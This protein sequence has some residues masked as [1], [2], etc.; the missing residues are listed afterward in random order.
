MRPE[1]RQLLHPPVLQHLS[2]LINPT[3]DLQSSVSLDM[4]EK[5]A[6][7]RAKIK[8]WLRSWVFTPLGKVRIKLIN[9]TERKRYRSISDRELNWIVDGSYADRYPSR[10]YR[11]RN[12]RQLSSP[13]RKRFL[14]ETEDNL[15]LVEL[16]FPMSTRSGS[17]QHQPSRPGF[18]DRVEL[19]VTTVQSDYLHDPRGSW[20]GGEHSALGSMNP[21][22]AELSSDGER[23]KSGPVCVFEVGRNV[24]EL[25]AVKVM[26]PNLP[27]E[28]SGGNQ[29]GQSPSLYAES[30][31]EM[32]NFSVVEE[33]P[34]QLPDLYFIHQPNPPLCCLISSALQNLLSPVPLENGICSCVKFSHSI[35]PSIQHL[36]SDMSRSSIKRAKPRMTTAEVLIRYAK[37]RRDAIINNRYIS[38]Y[39]PLQPRPLRIRKDNNVTS[40]PQ[41]DVLSAIPVETSHEVTAP[42]HRPRYSLRR[43]IF[44][45]AL[46][47]LPP[48]APTSR[49]FSG[50]SIPSSSSEPARLSSQALGISSTPA[51]SSR[52]A[53]NGLP[54]YPDRR[55][56]MCGGC[57]EGR[58]RPLHSHP[59]H[60]HGDN[61][62]QSGSPPLPYPLSPRELLNRLPPGIDYVPPSLMAGPQCRHCTT[63]RSGIGSPPGLVGP[64]ALNR[65]SVSL[66]DTAP[67]SPWAGPVGSMA[68]YYDS[69]EDLPLPVESDHAESVGPSG[70]E[71]CLIAGSAAQSRRYR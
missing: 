32:A 40:E 45:G 60:R 14:L 16:V 47:P 55:T 19:A 11:G 4:S 41:H 24:Y 33:L 30:D 20:R 9:K 1:E 65:V 46:P 15:S 5:Q 22:L 13:A 42:V 59:Y 70:F 64:R 61:N 29:S 63:R 36:S 58:H 50:S 21:D 10:F 56:S 8:R 68:F 23:S 38:P 6:R 51:S 44:H 12:G 35:E 25:S 31:G 18:C 52:P 3:S 7:K 69:D 49:P 17:S 27:A 62:P 34:P 39:A 43:K 2:L 53:T 67:D 26:S 48:S 71:M 54:Q 66:S 28:L 37:K 57:L